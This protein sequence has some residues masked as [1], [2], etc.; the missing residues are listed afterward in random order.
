MMMFKYLNVNEPVIEAR[1]RFFSSVV[2][3]VDVK[4]KRSTIIIMM[5]M[6]MMP[7]ATTSSCVVFDSEMSSFCQQ[8]LVDCH[9]R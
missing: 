6:M 3:D 7:P 5:M 9:E 1:W 2:D 8:E 4:P